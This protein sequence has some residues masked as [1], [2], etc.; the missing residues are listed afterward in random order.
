MLGDIPLSKR[1]GVFRMPRWEVL[2]LISSVIGAISSTVAAYLAFSSR[3]KR[4]RRVDVTTDDV[5]C[6]GSRE[7]E[8]TFSITNHEQ[9]R[10][11]NDFFLS[12][13]FFSIVNIG[14]FELLRIKPMKGSGGLWVV[15]NASVETNYVVYTGDELKPMTKQTFT[16]VLRGLP[17]EYDLRWQVYGSNM[18]RKRG[19]LLLE[20]AEHDSQA[21]A[22]HGV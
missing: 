8:V 2:A 7:W 18:K 16:V 10:F 5:K 21:A 1:Q 17:G 19:D 22:S 13:H 3:T 6:N 12:V 15:P 14:N 20:L 9:N 4:V 11:L